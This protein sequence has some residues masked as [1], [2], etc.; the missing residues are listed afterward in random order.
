MNRDIRLTFVINALTPGGAEKVM[1]FLAA[2]FAER[3]AQVTL[4][5]LDD[6]SAPPFFPLHPAVAHR[7]L[8]LLGR[9][10][11]PLQAVMNNLRRMYRLR[12]AIRESRPDTVLSFCDQTNVLTI[13]A[14]CGLGIRLVVAERSNPQLHTPVPWNVLRRLVYPMAR[15]VVVLTHEAAQIFSYH[16]GVEVI[17]NP[18]AVPQIGELGPDKPL[19]RPCVVGLGRFTREKRFDLLIDAFAVATKSTPGWSLVL[20]GDGPERSS[21]ERQIKERGLVGSVWLPG[22]QKRPGEFLS[23]ADLFVL[24][25]DYEG[26]PNSLCEAMAHG[27]AVIATDCPTGP[28]H[29]VRDAVD[30]VL[31]PR[32]NV[33]ALA[34][35][36]GRL[37]NN[38]DERVRLGA[39]AR[40]VC[41]RFP[42]EHILR[43]WETILVSEYA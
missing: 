30:G 18:V 13:L 22:Y 32:A 10:S 34:C 39:R 24:C 41:Q 23:Q 7:S 37:M 11:G 9:S 27:A 29:I 12:R 6:G 36:M 16:P 40:E 43:Q 3:G 19:K 17:P 4:L 8:A 14:A 21:L 42:P 31:V 26:F 2:A 35:A 38:R 1:T 20:I 25:S 28:R 5:S 15:H 33:E